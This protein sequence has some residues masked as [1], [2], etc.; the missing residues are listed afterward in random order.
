MT[1]PDVGNV[2][3]DQSDAPA[4]EV[5]NLT[6]VYDQHAAL[7]GVSFALAQQSTLAVIG[8]SGSGKS[9]LLRAIAG[10]EP[11]TAGSVS[12]HGVDRTSTPPHERRAGLMFQDHAL[13]P[14]LDVAAN[15]AFGMKMQRQPREMIE[16][17]TAEVLELVGMS[18][19]SHRKVE[20][21][22]GGEAQRVALARALAPS[23][24]VLLLD[25]PLGSL[26]RALRE[27]LV[28][29]LRHLFTS[30]DLAVVHVTH[31]QQEA[32]ALADQVIV[33]RD[34]SVEQM[35][36]PAEIWHRPVSVSVAAFLG[37]P[38]IWPTPDGAVLAPM[39]GLSITFEPSG[40]S[41]GDVGGEGPV[42][43]V[44]D[45]AEFREGRYRVTA[46]ER[47]PRSGEPR[48]FV[49][50]TD[51]IPA[52][53]GHPVAYVTIDS[54]ALVPLPKGWGWGRRRRGAPS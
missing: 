46:I 34:G 2:P 37:H 52:L 50:D 20:T 40:A 24:G 31:D 10:L 15:V 19:F 33:L 5:R 43:V 13:F 35:G 27:E 11:V 36:S 29:E 21:L 48:R 23:P 41:I 12:I 49:V 6:V 54:S 51:W 4:V 18:D 22:S 42:E 16:G 7:A 3:L 32:F 45:D 17:R 25:E 30:L 39:Q 47:A 53:D 8:P 26:D 9:T 44:V 38:N 14:H 1:P 28:G